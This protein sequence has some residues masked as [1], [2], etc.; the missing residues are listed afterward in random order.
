MLCYNTYS[1]NI[2]VSKRHNVSFTFTVA[3]PW[4]VNVARYAA[5]TQ[6]SSTPLGGA[7]R[8]VD[9][10]TSAIW[11][12]GSC[13]FTLREPNPWWR[14]DLSLIYNVWHV[15]VTHFKE[16]KLV[17]CNGICWRSSGHEMDIV[18]S[19][20]IMKIDSLRRWNSL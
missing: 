9:G 12:H 20:I 3:E 14:A 17:D 11:W 2:P 18:V 1:M 4:L 15:A 7:T 19:Q 16:R 8:A 10:G 6:S 5:A 13:S